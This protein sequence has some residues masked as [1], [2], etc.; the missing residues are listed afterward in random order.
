L[1][2]GEWR[3]PSDHEKNDANSVIFHGQ[4]REKGHNEHRH[5][6]TYAPNDDGHWLHLTSSS[7]FLLEAGCMPGK[8][9][10]GRPNFRA[11]GANFRWRIFVSFWGMSELILE[12]KSGG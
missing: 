2:I 6:D 9:K 1:Q 7:A 11:K 8:R 3:K 10:V 4:R 5:K 12:L